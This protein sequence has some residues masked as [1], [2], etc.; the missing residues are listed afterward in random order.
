MAIT[1]AN[2]GM[3]SATSDGRVKQPSFHAASVPRAARSILGLAS[4]LALSI[5]VLGPVQQASSADPPAIGRVSASGITGTSASAAGGST[6]PTAR[7]VYGPG[8]AGDAK[9]NMIIDGARLSHRFRAS[10]TSKLLSIRFQQRGGP[11]YSKGDGGTLRMSVQAD[12]GSAR[13][14]PSGRVLAALT[15][16]PGNPGGHWTTYRRFVFP[17]PATLSKGRIY[18]IVFSNVSSAP[19]SNYISVN[20][21]FTFEPQRHPGLSPVYAVLYASGG[22]WE[23]QDRNTADM[24]LTYADGRH[25]G[26]A[27]IENMCL[28]FGVVSGSSHSVRERFTVSAA[29]RTVRRVWVRVK[30]AYGASPLRVRLERADGTVISAASVTADRVP[31]SAPGCTRGGAVWVSATFA[32]PVTPGERLDLQPAP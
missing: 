32:S 14:L 20:E 28:L 22:G 6:T 11:A 8:I 17:E 21:L 18:H 5:A 29:S 7:K 15:V 2:G 16:R 30:R 31:T 13:H 3:M 23:L 4:M 12:D 9:N 1:I 10:T 24:D 19:G 25:D 26:Q 27:Y